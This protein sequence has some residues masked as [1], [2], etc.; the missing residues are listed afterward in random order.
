MEG[1][2]CGLPAVAVSLDSHLDRGYECAAALGV[3]TM[4]WAMAHP[5][6]RGEI[7][8]LNVPCGTPRGL[9]SA[10]VSNEYIFSPMYRESDEGYW[11]IEGADVVP[12]TDENSD[13]LLTR[14][15]YATLSIIRWN[16]LA[17]TPMPDLCAL[18]EAFDDVC[19]N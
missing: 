2:L 14:A 9:R 11:L 18:E 15:G 4:E 13:L 19:R 3:R 6:P 7:Y 8:N 10:T 5:L 1:A 17:D 12:E 16:L